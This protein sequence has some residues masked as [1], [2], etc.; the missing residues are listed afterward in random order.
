MVLRG[1]ADAGIA[2]VDLRHLLLA[3]R[4]QERTRGSHP[5]FRMAGVEE[6][7][8]LQSDGARAKPYQVRQVRQVILRHGLGDAL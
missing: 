3:L 4:F 6:K 8:N 7:I 2:F 1:T 5:L